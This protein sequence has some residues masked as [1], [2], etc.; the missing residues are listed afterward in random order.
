MAILLSAW[1]LVLAA[2]NR[3]L[4]FTSSTGDTY[5]TLAIIALYFTGGVASGAIIG[6]LSGL[7]RWRAGAW[8]LGGLA[9]V[10]L[11]IGVLLLEGRFHALGRREIMFIIV[12]CA[13]FGGGGGMIIR[14]FVRTHHRLDES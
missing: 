5:S 14:E 12:F 9:A 13:A 6:S 1:V 10:P 2:L 8:A 7:L 4:T 3:S 11:A